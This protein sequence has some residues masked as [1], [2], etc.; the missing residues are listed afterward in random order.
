MLGSSASRLAGVN[1]WI[2]PDRGSSPMSYFAA[3]NS[4]FFRFRHPNHLRGGYARMKGAGGCRRPLFKKVASRTYL[5][6][7][8]F[9]RAAE[10]PESE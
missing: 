8:I 7:W 4:S 3:A 2:M 6:F 9:C 5:Q 1:S 10:M